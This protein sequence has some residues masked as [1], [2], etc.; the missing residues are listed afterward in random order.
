MFANITTWILAIVNSYLSEDYLN[1]FYNDASTVYAFVGEAIVI[2]IFIYCI[3]TM[4]TIAMTK[5]KELKIYTITYYLCVK[6]RGFTSLWEY[7]I[8][9]YLNNINIMRQLMKKE[10]KSYLH[11]RG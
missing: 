3:K 8:D 1:S 4:I 6:H 2:L 5:I 11:I 7:S 10:L 9:F